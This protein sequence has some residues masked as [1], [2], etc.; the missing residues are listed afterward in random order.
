M[1]TGAFAIC[2]WGLWEF[3]TSSLVFTPIDSFRTDNGA[4][5]SQGYAL[6]NA[7]PGTVFCKISVL[8]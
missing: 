1:V 3:L 8:V 5:Y 7:F 4:T 6:P 2:V